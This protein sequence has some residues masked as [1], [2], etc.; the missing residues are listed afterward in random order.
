[1]ALPAEPERW[2][3]RLACAGWRALVVSAALGGLTYL[4]ADAPFA[5]GVALTFALTVAAVDLAERAARSRAPDRRGDLALA[6]VVWIAASGATLAG[7]AHTAFVSARAGGASLEAAWGDAFALDAVGGW[8]AALALAT[9]AGCVAPGVLLAHLSAL[10]RLA[11]AATA[12]L[13]G[14][15][16]GAL[17]GGP[18]WASLALG[19]FAAL[20][21]VVFGLLGLSALNTLDHVERLVRARLRSASGDP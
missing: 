9:L 14:T 2:P 11:V 21:A 3:R 15:V 1:M 13:L 5:L 17:A 6:A 20:F 8:P 12:S 19:S 16:F 4:N 7:A 10:P 18:L